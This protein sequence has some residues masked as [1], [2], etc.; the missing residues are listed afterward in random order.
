MTKI[1][2]ACVSAD[3]TVRKSSWRL[4]FFRFF[5]FSSHLTLKKHG[6]NRGKNSKKKGRP[7]PLPHPCQ[8]APRLHPGEDPGRPQAGDEHSREPKAGAARRGEHVRIG[9]KFLGEKLQ[10]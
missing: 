6:K 2:M 1:N 3:G 8:L 9:E 5:V 7:T 10:K 4:S